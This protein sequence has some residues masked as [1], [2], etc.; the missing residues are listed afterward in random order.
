MEPVFNIDEVI[1]DGQTAAIEST[2]ADDVRKI[3]PKLRTDQHIW[4]IYIFLLIVSVIELFSAS[5]QE[6]EVNDIYG[7]IIRHARFLAIGLVLMLVIQRFHF[8]YIY[9]LTPLYVFGSIMAMLLVMAAGV[10]VNGAQRALQFGSIMILPAEFLKLAAAL[11]IAYI[12]SRNQM[13]GK[14]DVTTKGVVMS[15][16]LTLLCAGLL[17]SHGLTNTLLI[18]AISMSMMLIGGVGMKKFGVVC[19]VYL[20]IGSAAMGYKLLQNK[21]KAPTPEAIEMARLNKEEVGAAAA[22]RSSTWMARLQRHFRL[23]KAGDKIDDTNKQEQLSYIAQAHGG[24]IG[25]GPGNSRENA[26]LPL[27]FS[28]YIYAI[29]IEELGLITGIFILMCYLWLLARAGRVATK[30]KQTFPC[31]LVIGCAIYIVYQALFHMAI[32]TGLFPV[33]GQPLPLISKGGTSV[34]VTSIALGIMLSTSRHAAFKGDKEAIREELNTLPASIHS[35]NP[36][37]L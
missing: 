19:L 1:N 4:G 10:K 28:D 20:V 32:V 15:A 18:F 31:L 34:I 21:D 37:Q 7:P 36:S 24:I 33:S 22:N 13:P 5:S 8:K 9:K 27:A 3:T 30:C 25:V 2:P 29:V 6:V 11:G 12:L 14:R 26:R 16:C 23:N 17:F 35:E